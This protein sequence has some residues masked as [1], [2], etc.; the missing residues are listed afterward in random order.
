MRI[1]SKG[2]KTKSAGTYLKI[3]PKLMDTFDYHGPGNE[4][5]FTFYCETRFGFLN[6]GYIASMDGIGVGS[7][8]S[9]GGPTVL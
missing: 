2:L 7:G 4:L 3:V 9:C 8:K 5:M 1:C 6:Q